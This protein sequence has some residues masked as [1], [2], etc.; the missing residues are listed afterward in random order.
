MPRLEADAE[1]HQRLTRDIAV[2]TTQAL[3]SNINTAIE[4]STFPLRGAYVEA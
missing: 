2:D 1:L 4:A 3:W